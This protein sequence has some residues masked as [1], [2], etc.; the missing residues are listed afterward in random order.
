MIVGGYMNTFELALESIKDN[1]LEDTQK[2]IQ[3]AVLDAV[4]RQDEQGLYEFAQQFQQIGFIEQAYYI[5]QE[6]YAAWPYED[7]TLLIAELHVENGELDE[8]LDQLLTIEPDS[9]YYPVALLAIAE[10]YQLQELY[11]VALSK[12]EQAKEIVGSEPVIDLAMAELYFLMGQFQQALSFYQEVETADLIDQVDIWKKMS[13]T[14]IVM[15]EFEQ[16][17][18]YL[19]RLSMDEHSSDTLFECGLAYYQLEEYTRA[20]H[21]FEELLARDPDY[22]SAEH[23]L[24]RAYIEQ[25]QDD[26]AQ[27]VLEQALEKNP[28]QAVLYHELHALYVK[29]QLWESLE[30][31]FEQAQKHVSD[32]TTMNVYYA[33]YLKQQ[34][35]MDALITFVQKQLED[36]EDSQYYWLLASA[37]AYLEEDDQAKAYFEKAYPLFNED[38]A[39]LEEYMLYVREIG[40]RDTMLKLRKEIQV[41]DPDWQFE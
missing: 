23:Y 12:L 11:E 20:I 33:Y 4:E 16:A 35:E 41:I 13:R 29:Q 6:G 26:R 34:E 39:F 1:R 30:E 24:A 9:Q 14:L 31:L 15:G 18:V 27:H 5:A 2:Y 3:E 25:G 28:Y 37:Y 19:E 7:W 17:V 8:A 32:D 36:D 40:E 22:L 21:W 10:V 38:V